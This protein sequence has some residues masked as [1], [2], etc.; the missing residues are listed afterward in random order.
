M[1]KLI[2]LF[3][4]VVLFTLFG[5]L[6]V[7]GCGND[8]A[9]VKKDSIVVKGVVVDKNNVPLKDVFVVEKKGL[10]RVL[11]NEN[12][13]FSMRVRYG[14]K[15]IFSCEGKLQ[16]FCKV[17]NEQEMVVKMHDDPNMET[18][19]IIGKEVF[20]K[21]MGEDI[22]MVVEDMPRFPEGDPNEYVSK[23]MKYPQEARD[24][25]IEGKVA[26]QFVIERDGKISNVKILRSIHPLLDAE[27]VRIIKNMPD[28]IPGK[29][30]GETV[31]VMYTMVVTFKL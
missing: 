22:F 27:T 3:P 17:K 14:A 28:W 25:K 19:I 11:T 20:T 7:F 30:R 9:K 12:G 13:E 8:V 26:V 10:M 4:L 29:Q 1:N 24:K 18:T 21:E 16:Q 2:L 15:L 31:R 23:N 5:N 6:H